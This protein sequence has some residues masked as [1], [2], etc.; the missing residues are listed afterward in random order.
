MK[1]TIFGGKK[2]MLAV[3]LYAGGYVRAIRGQK[4]LT[5]TSTVHLE[6]AI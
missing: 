4:N 3:F 6:I 1:T 5:L 2:I